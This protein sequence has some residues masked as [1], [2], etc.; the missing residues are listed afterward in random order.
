MAY[1][2]RGQRKNT[3]I[4]LENMCSKYKE[5][6]TLANTPEL[7]LRYMKLQYDWGVK[8]LKPVQ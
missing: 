8:R 3:E 1:L 2:L 4:Y 6:Y 7:E 5:L